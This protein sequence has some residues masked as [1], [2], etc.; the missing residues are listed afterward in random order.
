MRSLPSIDEVLRSGVAEE[1]S[2]TAPRWAVA[3]AARRAVETARQ[4]ILRGESDGRSGLE[5][6]VADLPHEVE[7]LLAPA[8]RRVIN[9]TGVILHTNL[10][11]APMP[12]KALERAVEI[13]TGYSNLELDLE[14]GLRG[15]RHGHL[16]RIL[17]QLTGAEDAVVV[18]N[19]AAAVLLVAT[20]L[21]AGREAIVSR[22]ELVEIGGAFRIPEVLSAGGA[23]LR[24]VG[25]TN[26]TRI[27][28]YE[29]ALCPD[30]AL[31]LK[32]HRSNFAV[33]GF[34]EE[35]G[36][37]ELALLGRRAGVP[38]VEDLGSGAMMD[39]GRLGVGSEPTA[40][41]AIESGADLVT[42]SGD[43]LLGG[44]QAGVIVG[45]AALVGRLRKHP[46]MRAVRPDKLTLASLEATLE[47]YRDSRGVDQ[48]PILAMLAAKAGDLRDRAEKLARLCRE[49]GVAPF[50]IQVRQSTGKVGGGAQPLT[51]LPGFA[52]VL[53]HTKRSA[54]DI[55]AALRRNAPPVIA[56]VS[57]DAVWLDVRTLQGD[58]ELDLVARAVGRI[59]AEGS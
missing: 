58:E 13:A 44:P 7:S 17:R 30:S 35:V 56:R 15:S 48:V 43:K 8:I 11:R 10:G 52:L 38:V 32:V 5:R 6:A 54:V 1:L 36:I 27:G 59:A 25:T 2:R 37:G 29:A 14:T 41:A 51:E 49:Q 46:L 20:A 9:A 45:R 4:Q 55:E 19:N 24:E 33:V 23:R 28:D 31:L 22:G 18:N 39:L 3:E 57:E 53:R 26:R 50:A 21:A 40:A 12:R 47:L 34:T 42:V 16:A